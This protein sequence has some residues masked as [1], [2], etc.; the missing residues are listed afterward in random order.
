MAAGEDQP[1][2]IV[3]DNVVVQTFIR[4]SRRVLFNLVRQWIESRP[5]A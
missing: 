2:P 5:S 4:I 3:L 1:Q